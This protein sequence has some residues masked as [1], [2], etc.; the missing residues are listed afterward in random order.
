M[1]YTGLTPRAAGIMSQGLAAPS[2][3]HPRGSMGAPTYMETRVHG[4]YGQQPFC[5]QRT[6]CFMWPSTTMVSHRESS[7][8]TLLE[9]TGFQAFGEAIQVSHF[10]MAGLV[11]KH[12]IV[13][14]STGS[15]PPTKML[16]TGEQ[17][18][19]GNKHS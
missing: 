7:M 18:L 11:I 6:L 3:S 14:A 15:S 4:L 5:P 19:Y 8:E 9:P 12:M 13:V 2:L 10:M 16:C 17:E 1:G